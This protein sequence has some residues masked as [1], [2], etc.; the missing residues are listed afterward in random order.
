MLLARTISGTDLDGDT[1]VLRLVGPGD[2]RVVQQP[3]PGATT[4]APAG[5]PGLIDSITVAGG[6]P[7]ETR[8]IG[9]VTKGDGGDGKVFFQTLE[10]IG[11]P[12]EGTTSNLG[13][14]AIDMPDFW[15]GQ[16]GSTTPT[17]ATEPKISIPDGVV[18][19]RFGGVDTTFA[20][21]GVTP[22]SANGQADT[23][24][25]SLGLPRTWGTSI[26]ID[27]SISSAE[28]NNTGSATSPSFQNSVVFSV[29]GRLNTFQANEI[30]GDTTFPSSGFAT[31]GGTVVQSLPVTAASITGQIGFLQVGGNATDLWVQTND[32][33]S[34]LYIGGETDNVG[35]LAPSGI[36]NIEFG[37]GM[38]NVSIQAHW[39]ETLQA[40]R[41]A[42]G[43]NVTSDRNIDRVTIGGD[44]VNTN[45]LAGYQQGLATV[46]NNQA[47]N[48]TPPDPQPGG[49]IGTVLIGGDVVN[50]I[51]A[52]SVLPYNGLF[53]VPE[54]LQF[55]HAH[56]SAKL[57][58]TIQNDVAAP[59]DPTQAFF[60]K[61][62][63]VTRGPIIPPFVPE[64][65]FPHPNAPPSGSRVLRV[66]QPVNS[67]GAGDGARSNPGGGGGDGAA[68]GGTGTP[69]A[70]VAARRAAA[71][72]A[73]VP[74]G[75]AAQARRRAGG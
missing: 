71:R 12:G 44:V 19:L 9:T 16:T 69:A 55:P 17:S 70:M 54:A 68:S 13:L 34:N 3:L 8:L 11:G 14:F 35:V 27:K 61:Q 30:D 56:I 51:F 26:I 21:A 6:D 62:A 67:P 37:K 73:A 25:V 40:N 31:G 39:I 20:P 60:A 43:S 52:A 38:D 28:P 53:D 41:G 23:F 29:F 64:L 72:A 50:S 49:V 42:V 66:L 7:A 65:P 47:Q 63:N 5:S 4:V 24:S 1:W 75:P 2:L 10:E 36:R 15:L 74:R 58:G 18:N 22:P 45:I 57:T 46:F 33:I 59:S 48:T 32:R